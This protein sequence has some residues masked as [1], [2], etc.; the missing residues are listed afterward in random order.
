MDTRTLVQINLLIIRIVGGEGSCKLRIEVADCI[1]RYLL[2]CQIISLVVKEIVGR[3][4]VRPGRKHKQ[5]MKWTER[6][7]AGSHRQYRKENI[8]IGCTAM[9]LQSTDQ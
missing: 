1:D 7:L 4:I 2:G 9:R 5:T 3:L 6:K 8:L